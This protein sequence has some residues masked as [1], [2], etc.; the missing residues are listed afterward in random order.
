MSFV[1]KSDELRISFYIR[2]KLNYYARA[3]TLIL[4]S[5]APHC[6]LGLIAVVW[7]SIHNSSPP[8]RSTNTQCFIGS[9]LGLTVCLF[10]SVVNVHAPRCHA[11]TPDSK[12]IK[13]QSRWK[14]GMNRMWLAFMKT[15]TLLTWRK[16]LRREKRNH[17]E[18][19]VSC[20][21]RKVR[22]TTHT[23]MLLRF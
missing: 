19:G 5:I 18:R 2:V 4:V 6:R 1:F 23:L 21:K 7:A 12:L 22:K 14:K 11:L 3:H 10:Y 16:F 15:H 17:S 9:W 8:L 20:T 13:R